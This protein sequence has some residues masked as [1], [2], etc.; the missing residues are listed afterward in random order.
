MPTPSRY[1]LSLLRSTLVYRQRSL[2][3]AT[4]TVQS[5]C[6]PV[7][8]KMKSLVESGIRLAVFDMA[9]TT[10]DEGGIVYDTLL[11]ELRSHK[12]PVEDSEFSKWHG[13]NKKNVVQHFV[14]LSHGN[15]S[16]AA[17]LTDEIYGRFEK[18]LQRK[19][20]ADNSPV[21][22][23]SGITEYFRQLR[24]R[25]I[26]IALD[27]GYPRPLAQLLVDRLHFG[28]M[29][30]L[31][32]TSDDVGG[33]GRPYPYMIHHAMRELKI[34]KVQEVAKFGDTARDM[35]EGLNAGCS[36]VVGVLSGADAAD[37]LSEAGATVIVPS[38]VQYP[39][40]PNETEERDR[41]RRRS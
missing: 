39:I 24:Q 14:R 18:A 35:E 13:A 26:K 32:V 7:S 20:E 30:D 38:V 40:D 23:V 9:G 33:H 3:F 1:G 5:R 16:N 6:G 10:V 37:T 27:T 21:K 8:A 22:E 2:I 31:L 15:D 29:I 28:P 34:E 36:L 4:A 12:I 11:D 41:K 19:Y 25:D 17:R